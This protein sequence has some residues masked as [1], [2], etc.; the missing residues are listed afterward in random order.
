[1]QLVGRF[2]ERDAG[3]R[4]ACQLLDDLAGQSE[5]IL[6]AVAQYGLGFVARERWS[7]PFQ[8]CDAFG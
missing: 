1:M 4:D 7:N 2:G 6:L 5:G 8:D 3:L